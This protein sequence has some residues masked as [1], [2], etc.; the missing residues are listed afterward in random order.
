MLLGDDIVIANDK[1]AKEYMRI[2]SEWDVDFNKIKTHTSLYGFEF[3]KQIRLHGR[4][5]SPFPL[6]ALYERRTESI[7]TL[8]ILLSEVKCKRWESDISDVLESYYLTIL[9]WPRPR[10][11]AFKPTLMLVISLIEYL[12]GQENLGNAIKDYVVSLVGPFPK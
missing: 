9:K 10:F 11:R 8:G 1:V 5:V 3:A 7:S 4:N 12:Q 6:S 2:L